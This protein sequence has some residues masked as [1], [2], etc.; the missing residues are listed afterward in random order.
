MPRFLKF[1]ILLAVLSVPRL[2]FAQG[3]VAQAP[4][5]VTQYDFACWYGNGLIFDCGLSS[6]SPVTLPATPTGSLLGNA[7][8]STTAAQVTALT[9]LIDSICPGVAQGNLIYRD[10]AAWQCLATGTSGYFLQ[11]NG[12][13][14]NPSWAAAAGTTYSADGTTLSLSG[15][16]FSLITPVAVASGG[17]GLAS[18]TSGGV[19]G[20]TASG[21]LASSAALTAHGLVLGGGAGATPYPIASLGTSGQ[22]LQSNGPS[23]DPSWG[24]VASGTVTS[25]A[26]AS[27]IT[28]GTITATGTISCVSATSSTE[29][30]VTPDGTA[31]HFLNGAGSWVAA[32][33]ANYVT[34]SGTAQALT[35]G[36]HPTEFSNGTATTGTKTIDCG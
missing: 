30:C 31:T 26:T 24:A 3:A 36:F 12:F 13:A 19:L 9:A 18:G 7:T 1:L 32:T 34:L 8:G 4:G 27:G 5:A 29:G 17:T 22:V 33:N 21:T 20:Y 35:G 11:S 6:L 23:A 14:A 2:A 25:I 28:G 15:N 16:T 10:V